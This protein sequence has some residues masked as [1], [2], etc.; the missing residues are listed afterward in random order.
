MRTR[1]DV[2]ERE[3]PLPR[4]LRADWVCLR[5]G[6]PEPRDHP[7]VWKFVGF[8]RKLCE[9]SLFQV[10]VGRAEPNH[11]RTRPGA[12]LAALTGRNRPKFASYNRVFVV[13]C[14]GRWWPG[15]RLFQEVSKF[16]RG[17]AA[18]QK[19]PLRVLNRRVCLS[20]TNRALRHAAIDAFAI[21]RTH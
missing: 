1:D 17:A 15:S 4:P 7:E 19:A 5:S 21:R 3:R 9:V 13:C 8:S 18:A 12:C 20:D 16:L 10:K 11:P 14:D 2:P 6:A